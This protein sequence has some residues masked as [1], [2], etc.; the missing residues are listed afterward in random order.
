MMEKK[1]ITLTFSPCID[2]STTVPSLVP[3]KKLRCTEPKL[4]PG[5]GGLNVARAIK[6]LGG[7]ATAIY[8]SGGYT[9]KY[10]NHLVEKEDIPTIIIETDQETRENIIVFDVSG[11][12]QYRFGFPGTPLSERD[13][14]ECMLAIKDLDS[15]EYIVVSGSL[16]PGVSSSVYKLLSDIATK[17][18]AKLV[19]DAPG[20]YLNE[21]VRAGVYMIKPN[22]GELAGMV[23]KE[24]IEFE[25]IPSIARDIISKNNCEIIVVSLGKNGAMLFTKDESYAV[26]APVVERLSTVGAGDSMVAG[27]V[28]SLS[29]GLSLF[30]ALQY[31]VAS[32]TAATLRPGTELCD[33]EHADELYNTIQ[34]QS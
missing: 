29:S 14:N 2:K 3:E 6:K 11:N 7:E 28:Y 31:G 18:N 10:L 8:P 12:K 20:E 34:K 17:S 25:E 27:I 33:K 30:Q 1:I 5:G 22:I 19:V 26:Q 24:R 13:L 9:G 16:P 32:G 15:L 21:V 23:N 4:D